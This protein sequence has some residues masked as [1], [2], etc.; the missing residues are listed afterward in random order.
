[1]KKKKKFACVKKLFI[2][3]KCRDPVRICQA[4]PSFPSHFL[5]LIIVHCLEIGFCPIFA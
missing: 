3:E 1:M 4:F 5:R 2:I